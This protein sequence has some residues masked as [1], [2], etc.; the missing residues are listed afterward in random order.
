[1]NYAET[2]YVLLAHILSSRDKQIKVPKT[3]SH[4]IVKLFAT[5]KIISIVVFPQNL[6]S[7]I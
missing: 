5:D 6:K 3:G 2:Y 4:V 1:M 7:K